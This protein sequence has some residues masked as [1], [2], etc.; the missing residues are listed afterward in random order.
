MVIG[1]NLK[2]IMEEN[3]LVGRE[4]QD[5]TA[6]DYR[7]FLIGRLLIQYVQFIVNPIFSD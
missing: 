3:S 2:E 4:T 6:I 7:C 1:N 5:E